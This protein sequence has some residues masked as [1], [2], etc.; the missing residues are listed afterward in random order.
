MAVWLER[1]T[2][3]EFAALP[4]EST[5]IF[6]PVGAIE[7]HGPHLPMGLDLDEAQALCRLAAERL[8]AEKPG[9]RGV[10]A[11]VAPLAVEC[12]TSQF[13]FPVRG[14][15]LRDYL[16]D[17]GLVLMKQGF[18]YL[19]AFAGNPSPKQ[20]V[21][22][23]EAGRILARRSQG[24]A[25]K[26]LSSRAPKGGSRGK[27][28]LVSAQAGGT[29]PGDMWKTPFGADPAEH[30]GN[31]DT[32]VAMWLYQGSAREPKAQPPRVERTEVGAVARCLTKWKGKLS[33]YWGDPTKASVFTGE[34]TI[35]GALDDTFPKLR[36]WFEGAN[37]QGLFRSWHSVLPSNRTTF[38]AWMLLLLIAILFAGYVYVGTLG[39]GE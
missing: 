31:R 2:A 7:D 30:G 22:I 21:A 27:P 8:E 13:A 4:R 15:V 10:I 33:G 35:L 24:W 14:Y 28:G 32:S 11:P 37:P 6:F 23:E 20:V 29:V 16:V 39:L 5:V 38:K 36:A 34:T 3:Q 19:V 12:N 17:V 18:P 25:S 26:I 9:W 1:L